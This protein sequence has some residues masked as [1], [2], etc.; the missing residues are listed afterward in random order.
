MKRKRSEFDLNDNELKRLKFFFLIVLNEIY[1]EL[2][3][4]LVK[5]VLKILFR[6]VIV[7]GIRLRIIRYRMVILFRK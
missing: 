2:D 6:K 5:W 1:E 4:V 3:V 7:V